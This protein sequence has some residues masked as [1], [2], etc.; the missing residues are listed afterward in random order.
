[1]ARRR[2]G[3]VEQWVMLVVLR[4]GNGAFALGVLRELDREAGHVVSRGSLYK[5]LDRLADKGLVDWDL[6]EGSP[7]RGGHPRRK[8]RVTEAGL[9]ALSEERER[10]L[11]LW[12]GIEHL[13]ETER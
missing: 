13:L 9:E 3:E 12:A 10:L 2:M 5:T 6:E 1:M 11:N 8:F 4:L 7:A